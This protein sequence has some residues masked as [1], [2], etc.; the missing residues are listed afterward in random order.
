ML[1][2]H[3]TVVVFDLEWTTWEDFW[4]HGWSLPGKYPEIVQIGAVKLKVADGFREIAEFQA[5][6][7]PDRNPILSDY[8]IDLTGISQARVDGKGISFPMALEAFTHFIG[9][10]STDTASWG[11]DAEIILR[12]CDLYGF[13]IPQI[14]ARNIDLR[15]SMREIIGNKAKF[16][17][18][19]DLPAI[20]ELPSEGAAHDALADA[21]SIAA[22]LR[23][24][25]QKGRL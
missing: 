4:K 16:A 8:F 5:L 10:N 6:V 1:F 19:S 7:R 22:A 17:F 2:A 18:S 20:L 9:D 11:D 23:H 15:P 25:R 13:P 12:N 24:L 14:L 3:D 21:R